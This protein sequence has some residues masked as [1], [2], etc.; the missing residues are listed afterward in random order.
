MD[1]TIYVVKTKTLISCSVMRLCFSIYTCMQKNRFS[2]DPAHI[3]Q[4][5]ILR[6]WLASIDEAHLLH[7]EN[8]PMQQTAIFHWCKND[9]FH[10]KFL[11]Y[12]HIFA[13]N[14]DRG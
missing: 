14:I 8:M 1:C 13:Q 5:K 7:Y 11:N 12:F 10:L 4:S 9:N 6:L 3:S 2:Y